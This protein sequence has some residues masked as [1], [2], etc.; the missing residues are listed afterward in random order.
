MLGPR[1]PR[2]RRDRPRRDS[3]L[4]EDGSAGAGS[5]PRSWPRTMESLSELQ[6]PLLPQSPAP[7]HGPYPYRE[8][9]PSW[10]CQEKLYSYL[11]GAAG[12]ARPHQLLDPGSLQLAVE[13]WYRPSC[14]LGRDKVKEPRASSCETS[15]TENRELQAGPAERS[16][17]ADQEEEDITIQTVS[18]GVQEELQGQENNQEEEESDMTS[19][20]SESEDNFVALPPRDHLGLTIFSMLC[21]FWPLGIAAFYFSQGTSKA[22]SKGDFRLAST[23]SRRALFLATLSIAVGAGLYVAV[24]VALAAYMSQNGHG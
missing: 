24:V 16:T 3:R 18:Y 13:A 19:T 9:S 2:R 4:S 22:I 23:T 11:L 7:L 10:S 5:L 20:D 6:N 8:A 12:S 15:F 1:A 17:E 14:L 21:C